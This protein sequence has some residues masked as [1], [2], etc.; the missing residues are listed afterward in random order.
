MSFVMISF[1]ISHFCLTLVS[2][3]IFL[4]YIEDKLFTSLFFM[5]PWA[6]TI[7]KIAL[8]DVALVGASTDRFP[9]IIEGFLSR[10]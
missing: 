5:S 6:E 9:H 3:S 1:E 2:I 10:R 8:G 7:L 4:R